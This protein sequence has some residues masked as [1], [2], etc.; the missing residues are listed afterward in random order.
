MKGG[1]IMTYTVIKEKMEEA[2]HEN[3]FESLKKLGKIMQYFMMKEN[4]MESSLLN[5]YM[6]L[7]GLDEKDV[8][9]Y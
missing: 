7:H 8:V 2:L 4:G 3:D 6:E 9:G 1:F 5:H